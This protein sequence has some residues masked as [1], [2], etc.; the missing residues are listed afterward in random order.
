MKVY[1]TKGGYFYKELKNGKKTRISKEKY[2]KL[3]KTQTI[4]GGTSLFGTKHKVTL[5]NG[6]FKCSCGRTGLSDYTCPDNVSNSKSD[7]QCLGCQVRRPSKESNY[8]CRCCGK[9]YNKN[10]IA[11]SYTTWDKIK[12]HCGNNRTWKYRNYLWKSNKGRGG[13]YKICSKC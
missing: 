9:S 8:E 5:H 11:P 2:Q 1:R 10:C 3:R 13:K 6:F 12:V 4:E 7:C